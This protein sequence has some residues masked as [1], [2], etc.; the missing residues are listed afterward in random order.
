MEVFFFSLLSIVET[1][2]GDFTDHDF[3]PLK[4]RDPPRKRVP[5]RVPNGG[6]N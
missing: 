3:S 2:I 6:R 1:I 4:S 5:N